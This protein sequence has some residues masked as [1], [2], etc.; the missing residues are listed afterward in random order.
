MVVKFTA[1]RFAIYSISTAL[2]LATIYN[3][4]NAQC[5]GLG[6]ITFNIVAAPEPTLDFPP[7]ICNGQPA[8]IAV[9]ETFNSY[10]WSTGSTAS[11]IT[12]NQAGTYTVTVTNS[13][14]CEGSESAVIVLNTPSQPTITGNTT[15]CPGGS[16]L[17]SLSENYPGILWSS[18]QTTQDIT[19]S[20]V[21]TYSVTI[22]DASGCTASSSVVVTAGSPLSFPFSALPSGCGQYTLEVGAVYPSY[23]WS[24]GSTDQSIIVTQ[25]GPYAVTVTDAGGCTGTLALTVVIPPPSLVQITGGQSICTSGTTTLTA[26]SGFLAY[27]WSNGANTQTNT[28]NQPG[29]Y[30]VTATDGTGCTSTAS[31]TISSL[32]EP[33]P[34]VSQ[35][36]PICAG[37]TATISVT[38]PIFQNYN[39]SNGGSGSSINVSMAGTYTVTVTDA[40]GC[41]GTAAASLTVNPSPIVAASQLPYQCNGLAELSATPGFPTYVWS[42]GGSTPSITVNQPGSY[43]VTV[44]GASGCTTTA[45]VN[46]TV[47]AAPQA[48]I[49][50][51]PVICEGASSILSAT[52]GFANYLWN[53]GQTGPS[54]SVNSTG[55]Y[56]VTVTNSF[57]C[58]ATSSFNVTEQPAPVPQITGPTQICAGGTAVFTATGG[59][60]ANYLWSNGSLASAIS[61]SAPGG[62]GLTVTD[63]NGCTSTASVDLAVGNSLNITPTELPFQCNGEIIL[64]AGAGFQS[65]AW[66]NGNSTQLVTVTSNGNFT[67]TV[68]DATG[69][70][71]SASAF[72]NIPAQ[73]QATISGPAQICEGESAALTASAGFANYLWSNGQQNPGIVATIAGT[74]DVTVTDVNGCQASA[75]TS[76]AVNDSPQPVITGASMICQN[77]STVL[78]AAGNFQNWLWS[79]GQNTPQITASAAGS[80]AVTVTDASGCTGTDDFQLTVNTSLQ[81]QI[82]AQPYACDGQLTLDAGAGFQ[83]YAW[84]NWGVSQTVVVSQNGNYEVTVSD[85]GGCTGTAVFNASIPAQPEVVISGAPT[86]CTGSSSVLTALAGFQNYLWSNGTAA[87]ET[88]VT[89]PGT[90]AVTA[91][92]ANG[93]T[94]VDVL[95]VVEN[96][97]PQPQISGST[98]LCNGAST[99]LSVSANFSTILWS[100]GVATPQITVSTAG[101]IGLQVT[102]ANGCS[103][104]ASVEVTVASS[105]SPQ[106]TAQPFACD[107]QLTLDAGAGF[108]TYTWSNGAASQTAVV[109]QNGNY[110]VTVSDAGGCTGTAVFNAIIPAQPEVVISGAQSICTGG[111]ATLTATAG[112]VGYAWSNGATTFATTITQPG[113]YSVTATDANGCNTEAAFPVLQDNII[114][115]A[116]LGSSII[117]NG[118]PT[119]LFLT[120]S[121]DNYEWSNG[122]TSSFITVATPGLVSVTVTNA[123]GCSGETSI[124]VTAGNN[125]DPQVVQLSQDCS[126]LVGLGVGN[127][128][129]TYLWS[130]GG[131]NLITLVD[132]T[133]IYTVTVTD[134]N[135]C[136][137][138]GSIFAQVPQQFSVSISG[139]T[140]F[141]PGGSSTLTAT[142]G[143]Q[144]YIWSNGAISAESTVSQAGNYSVTVSDLNGCT[145]TAQVVVT[146][147]GGT[148]LQIIGNNVICVGGSTDLS[149][150]NASNF[151]QILWS[152]GSTAPQ[153]TVTAA[154][155]YSVTATDG[156]GCTASDSFEVTEGNALLPSIAEGSYNCDGIL[157]LEAP[158][159]YAD[160]VWSTGVGTPVITVSQDGSYALT[161]T[162]ASGCTGTAIIFVQVPD[163]VVVVVQTPP[164]PICLG[165]T[166]LLS[167]PPGFASYAWNTGEASNAIVIGTSGVYAVTITD[168][169]GCTAS[170][171]YQFN[172]A[173]APDFDIIGDQLDCESAEAVLE[174]DLVDVSGSPTVLWSNGATT[175]ALVTAQPGIFTV[176]VT[177]GNGCTATEATEVLPQESF[178]TSFADTIEFV[179]GQVVPLVPPGVD[180]QPVEFTWSPTDILLD[181]DNCPTAKARPIEDVLVN[182]TAVSAAGCVQ[183]GTFFLF[184]NLRE[185]PSVY[186]PNAFSPESPFNPGF[187]LFG[188]ELVAEIKYLRVF[189]R[190]GEMV[191]ELKSLTPNDPSKGWD[192]SFRGELVD[193]G[194]FVWVAE[195]LYANGKTEVLKG[196]ITVVR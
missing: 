177:D 66:S 61:V 184:F 89:L 135:G 104:T 77:G 144:E 90:Y 31:T 165:D 46:A 24:T 2:T 80:Y 83:T 56:F 58:T 48:S 100:T 101:T 145:G 8:T 114:P 150:A 167:V 110:E 123:N 16:T 109:S 170:D 20:T 121:Y 13:A 82:T 156:S 113:L 36:T 195:V 18:G 45:S 111:A 12:V 142:S 14:G 105:L 47:P 146:V 93:C 29:T 70:T 180:F 129:E 118:N 50:G 88:T 155:T 17:L 138:V 1:R 76:L 107:G 151:T 149:I 52:P 183:E 49:T 73:P 116:L 179:P 166:A 136:T 139:N 125:L 130:N 92:D 43:T 122:S 196:D 72:V 63:G 162:D 23:L 187:T 124:E 178:F 194:V 55:T 134:A 131:T 7:S 25:T 119:T 140:V 62:Y 157:T 137:G 59:P 115:P 87:A 175:A 4:A 185:R 182:F 81:P 168:Q 160:Y 27:S 74:Y 152:N 32:P 79:G 85:A 28:I 65:Y 30:T 53:N 148:P 112:F 10:L 3:A 103:G 98:T 39:W 60:F 161:V 154:G 69:C 174:L 22:T 38:N 26:S 159:G 126:G 19:V 5:P 97:P 173:A 99:I 106:I 96:T 78:S 147:G 75:S 158:E 189:T 192:G 44:T 84:S 34:G 54:I 186:A 37:E 95:T 172:F 120:A 169:Y 117:C 108:L 141:C 67:V 193:P 86:F 33:V 176:T 9:N 68:T 57:A 128:Y 163:E 51:D 15:I 21:G 143:F 11:S 171:D 64:D 133:G 91:T 6:F 153:I 188:N 181:C 102:D 190:W 35:P 71:G 127:A 40:A 94:S 42:N 41:T 164:M 132:Q 191:V